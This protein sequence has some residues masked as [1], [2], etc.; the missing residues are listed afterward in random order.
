MVHEK[1]IFHRISPYYGKQDEL[2]GRLYK[3]FVRFEDNKQAYNQKLLD[4]LMASK[5]NA[6]NIY[7]MD[8]DNSVKDDEMMVFPIKTIDDS[9]NFKELWKAY[10]D[11]NCSYDIYCRD[12]VD[13]HHN[14]GEIYYPSN[15]SCLVKYS[16]ILSNLR[17]CIGSRL[18]NMMGISTV[19]NIMQSMIISDGQAKSFGFESD[20][21]KLIS[22]DFIPYDWNFI[23][24][25]HLDLQMDYLDSLETILKNISGIWFYYLSIKLG[26]ELDRYQVERFERDF[27]MQYLF[28]RGLCGEGDYKAK[29]VGALYNTN[30]KRFKLAP[31][32]DME[33]LFEDDCLSLEQ[34]I[35]LINKRYPSAL[36]GFVKRLQYLI[37]N[38]KMDELVDQMPQYLIFKDELKRIKAVLNQNGNKIIEIYFSMVKNIEEHELI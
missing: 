30:L 15:V 1:D 10:E 16:S 35:K 14:G 25:E 19:F 22:V 7:N 36:R 28:R 12:L 29:N 23:S 38:N 5:K 3:Y 2:D 13:I 17:E 18:S 6:D 8:S 4:Y 9:V 31:N 20:G 32:L 11:P 24:L 27:S 37:A 21:S 34:D 33:F 26:V